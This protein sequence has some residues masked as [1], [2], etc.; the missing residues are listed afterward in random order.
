MTLKYVVGVRRVAGELEEVAVLFPAIL[1]HAAVA[2]DL[3]GPRP[4]RGAGFARLD[5][6]HYIAHGESDSLG[7]K[8]RGAEDSLLLNI[9]AG[10]PCGA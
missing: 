8:S 10:L 5:E 1:P 9:Q 7:V 3:F 6:G 4:V 2:R